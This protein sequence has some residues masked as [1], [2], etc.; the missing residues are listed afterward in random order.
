VRCVHV[1]EE[2]NVQS[3]HENSGKVA[4]KGSGKRRNRAEK[5]VA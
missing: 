5:L 4:Q 2:V 1:G 3:V